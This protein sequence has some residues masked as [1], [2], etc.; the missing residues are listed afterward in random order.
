MKRGYMIIAVSLM[1]AAIFAASTV[2][3]EGRA[4][5][6]HGDAFPSGGQ[7]AQSRVFAK[8]EIV[9]VYN[10]ANGKSSSVV[11]TGATDLAGVLIL[12]SPSA[13]AELGVSSGY[14]SVVRVSRKDDF[15]KENTLTGVKG[16]IDPD[17]N[18]AANLKNDLTYTESPLPAG[19]A[20]NMP[21]NVGSVSDENASQNPVSQIKENRVSAYE[22]SLL[23]PL[24]TAS[25]AA[26]TQSGEV[27]PTQSASAQ[28]AA[29]GLALSSPVQ[30]Q[31]IIVTTPQV[32]I[33][34]GSAVISA[35]TVTTPNGA[36]P[37]ADGQSAQAAAS[38]IGAQS[39]AVAMPFP[40]LLIDSYAKGKY[41]VQL[42]VYRD[43]K[44]LS[45]VVGKYRKSYPVSIKASGVKLD[46]Y[47]MLIGPLSKDEYAAVLA[48]FRR[49]GFKDSFVKSGK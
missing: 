4:A 47:E 2:A 41:Y 49:D 16:G 25:E 6:G 23:P 13:A 42:G 22:Y 39:T 28:N 5:V 36:I 26:S 15:V 24:P 20:S 43:M 12:L 44:N 7:Y 3:W 14:D 27:D 33:E 1:A 34:T 45:G 18:T 31:S 30:V 19:V 37:S 17:Y 46:S 8:G 38:S 11:I 9:E 32:Q 48:T 10:T 29:N 35:A 40:E 21:E